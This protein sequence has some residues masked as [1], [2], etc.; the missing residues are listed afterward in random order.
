MEFGGYVPKKIKSVS[1]APTDRGGQLITDFVLRV[2][3]DDENGS[4]PITLYYFINGKGDD[5]TI[6]H[7]TQNFYR[8]F[9]EVNRYGVINSGGSGGAAIHYD[10][11]SLAS[12]EGEEVIY[13]CETDDA[14][15]V[16]VISRYCIP[17]DVK[18]PDDYIED[19]YGDNGY[20]RYL[21]T[22]E[23]Y[24]ATDFN[25][26]K[27]S[28]EFNDYLRHQ[29]YVFEKGGKSAAP[30]DKYM[31]IYKEAGIKVTD[32][33]GIDKIISDRMEELGVKEDMLKMPSED[34]GMEPSWTELK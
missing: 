11:Y 19:E 13:M 3:A 15:S 25:S 30:D 2:I 28:D 26:D 14:I 10:G 9:A 29:V 23:P 20:T 24:P 8:S 6:V 5:F 31:K 27:N 16:P 21:Y 7:S 1:L 17:D 33:A 22:F 18:L 34:P 12:P 4:E 32:K